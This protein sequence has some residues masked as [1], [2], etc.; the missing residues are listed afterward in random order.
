[1]NTYIINILSEAV[2]NIT[3]MAGVSGNESILNREKVIHNGIVV[4]VPTLS[5]NALRHNIFRATGAQ[6]I[7]KKY[8]LNK[9]LSMTQANFLANGGRLFESSA[10]DDLTLLKEMHIVS[11]WLKLLGGSLPN[12][13][14]AGSMSVSGGV[15]VCEENRIFINE[16]LGNDVAPEER[17]LSSESF[18]SKYQYTRGDASKMPE[19]SE[20]IKDDVRG[21]SNLMIYAGECIIRGALFAHKVIISNATELELGAALSCLDLWQKQGGKIGGSSRIGHG[22]LSSFISINSIGGKDDYSCDELINKYESY[23]ETKKD[24]FIKWLQKAIPSKTGLL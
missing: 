20:Y 16:I 8:N 21:E 13:V 24:Q 3:H 18:I 4:S 10:I 9:K 7:F 12:Q 2:S 14:I 19:A 22:S 5:G 23:M 1:M 17:M 6:M 11:P 15:L